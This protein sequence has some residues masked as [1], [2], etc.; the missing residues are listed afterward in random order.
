[1]M[2]VRS[3]YVKAKIDMT[4]LGRDLRLTKDAE[5][6]GR[7]LMSNSGMSALALRWSLTTMNRYAETVTW[8][9]FNHVPPH[10]PIRTVIRQLL[11][12]LATKVCDLRM[13]C[14]MA[15]V[16]RRSRRAVFTEHLD[17]HDAWGF[18]GF[19]SQIVA[20]ECQ[21]G[22]VFGTTVQ[23]ALDWLASKCNNKE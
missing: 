5:W 20:G 10:P 8:Q 16:H 2:K 6:E 21:F 23:E 7:E 22:Q 9:N 13:P 19:L 18:G 12:V 1:M 15:D 11:N 17:R 3:N 14:M 4:S